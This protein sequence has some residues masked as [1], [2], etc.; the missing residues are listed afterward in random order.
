M[1][2]AT[3]MW[4]LGQLREVLEMAQRIDAVGGRAA[5]ILL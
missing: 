5:G 1:S 2:D 3:T 4:P